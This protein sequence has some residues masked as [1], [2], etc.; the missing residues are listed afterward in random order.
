MV[1][2]DRLAAGMRA[3]AL[4]VA[5][6]TN[7]TTR[8]YGQQLLTAV[9]GRASGRPGPRAQTGDYRRSITLS[10]TSTA[11]SVSAQVGT[12][13]PQGRRLEYGF[14]PGISPQG[15]VDVLGRN[16]HQPPLA[17]FGPAFDQISRAYSTAMS[18]GIA[19]IVARGGVR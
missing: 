12:N 6:F 19:A 17:H 2:A 14:A 8:A 18:R 3:D 11:G 5:Q 15:G 4:A 16:F 1:N 10:I 9:R 7:T 13:S